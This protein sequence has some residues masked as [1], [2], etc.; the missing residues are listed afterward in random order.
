[1]VIL[2][3]LVT[4]ATGQLLNYDL[5]VDIKNIESFYVNG[6][7]IFSY[8]IYY[9]NNGSQTLNDVNIMA[10]LTWLS[11]LHSSLPGQPVEKRIH[12]TPNDVCL[13]DLYNSTWFYMEALDQ[14]AFVGSEETFS[15]F[16]ELLEFYLTNGEGDDDDDEDIDPETLAYFLANPGI[17]I[18][19]WIAQDGR[20]LQ[21]WF[22]DIGILDLGVIDPS[23]GVDMILGSSRSFDSLMPNFGWYITVYAQLL[24][25]AS[26]T[27][28]QKGIFSAT[29][30]LSHNP[31]AYLDDGDIYRTFANQSDGSVSLHMNKAGDVLF[32]SNQT[33]L[34]SII[35]ESMSDQ[36]KAIAIWQFVKD[37]TFNY[38]NHPGEYRDRGNRRRDEA[39]E[40]D[41]VHLLN[42]LYGMCGEI[43]GAFA[44]LLTMAWLT[45][46]RTE[47]GEHIATEVEIDGQWAFMDADGG[48]YW[49]DPETGRIYSLADIEADPNIINDNLWDYPESY[50]DTVTDAPTNNTDNMD[51]RSNSSH[52]M[53]FVL[54][55]QDTI[56]YTYY[57]EPDTEDDRYTDGIVTRHT[58]HESMLS[59]VS[60]NEFSIQEY[61][62][63]LPIAFEISVDTPLQDDVFVYLKEQYTNAEVPLGRLHNRIWYNLN[64]T[65]HDWNFAHKHNY[66]YT[67]RLECPNGCDI[68]DLTSRIQL[69]TRFIFNY[70]AL[71]YDE[72]IDLYIDSFS[73]SSAAI[74]AQVEYNT[75]NQLS[76]EVLAHASQDDQIARN[77]SQTFRFNTLDHNYAILPMSGWLVSDVLEYKWYVYDS[78][79]S[80]FGEDAFVGQVWLDLHN[81]LTI[82]EDI[83]MTDGEQN[84]Q[85]LLHSG[86]VI[87]PSWNSCGQELIL[88]PEDMTGVISGSSADMIFTV[89]SPCPGRT[90]QFSEDVRIRVA[91][92][93]EPTDIIIAQVSSD[94]YDRSDITAM[95]VDSWVIELYTPHFS[96]IQVSVVPQTSWGTGWGTGGWEGG[97]GWGGLEKDDCP[98]GDFSGSYYD[99]KC[100]GE[101]D[102][103]IDDII[104]G[105][106]LVEDIQESDNLVIEDS[107]QENSSYCVYD[108][109]DFRNYVFSDVV[110]TKYENAVATLLHHCLVHGYGNEWKVFGVY[111]ATKLGE[112]YKIFARL[113]LL[114][115]DKNLVDSHWSDPYKIAGESI[116]LWNGIRV[117]DQESFVTYRDL[118]LVTINYLHYIWFLEDTIPL[119]YNDYSSV[120]RWDLSAFIS[121]LIQSL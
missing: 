11:V 55:P 58:I 41:P 74:A 2:S 36:D 70:L 9:H 97:T 35:D 119:R 90:L 24:Q 30:T 25:N 118:L 47:H 77:N 98:D 114:E 1:M 68:A 102:T 39:D 13:P 110:G 82:A 121:M 62:P 65:E 15:T 76:I 45:A 109:G 54:Y 37:H 100:E 33:I 112:L 5:E 88:A 28:T 107:I 61:I 22:E 78:G 44:S 105:S 89:W 12:W 86:V 38:N 18:L 87:S 48:A 79:L 117:Q 120:F 80:L 32:F 52:T 99:G 101:D 64:E 111:N 21:D 42:T 75:Y 3:S 108:D 19:E 91:L 116:G 92:Q 17:F 49:T 4:L 56:T 20:S 26:S 43:N 106:W 29:T 104:T 71:P 59:G 10:N 84:I 103:A 51:N 34:D 57:D 60:A 31:E 95:R 53:L 27:T 14:W 85:V 46:R 50:A 94:G 115:F 93:S 7:S 73:W 81:T 16:T 67:L 69:E 40:K 8:D 113:A 72:D 66:R 6:G 96:Y 23:C 83:V 63:Y